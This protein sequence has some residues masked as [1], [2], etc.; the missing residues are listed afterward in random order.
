MANTQLSRTE[1]DDILERLGERRAQS[2]DE[3]AA[4][5]DVISALVRFRRFTLSAEPVK[6]APVAASPP[7]QSVP[8]TPIATTKPGPF[9]GLAMHEAAVKQLRLAGGPKTSVDIWAELSAGGFVSLHNDPAHAVHSVLARRAKNEADVVL[10]GK[11]MWDLKE[12]YSEAELLKI[13]KNL[14]GMPA[15]NHSAHRERTKAGMIV[16]KERGV[17]LGGSRKF[18]EEKAEEFLKLVRSG[19]GVGKACKAV[20]I[21]Y[22][23]YHNYKKVGLYEWK[24]GD[25]WP[26]TAKPKPEGN[27]E[28]SEPTPAERPNL[29]VVS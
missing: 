4:I 27:K 2:V 21:T 23:C 24:K 18:T 20:G 5:N 3:H 1:I 12:R 25:P 10:V 9:Y 13:Q 11:G 15:R 22:A 6:A 26:P 14:G 29:R 19:I 28:P 8:A 16:A 7:E 17:T